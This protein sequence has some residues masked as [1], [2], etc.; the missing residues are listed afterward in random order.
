[1]ILETRHLRLVTAV[2][3]HG[4]LT[5]AGRELNLT[6]SA[7]SHALL[8]LERRL[9]APLF[10]RVGKRMVPTAVGERLVVRARRV[11]QLLT[12]TEEEA[13]RIASG[14][15]GLIRLS[16][17]CYTCYHWLPGLMQAFG[18]RFPNVEVR[19][20]AEATR[21]PFRALLEGRI[22]LAIVHNMSADARIRHA[23]LFEDEL[24]VLTPPDHPFAR[25]AF[26]APEEL[27]A[28]HLLTYRL[29]LRDL[30]IYQ[31]VLGP[32]G[33]TPRR[34]TQ[35]ELT[36]ALIEMVRAGMGVA[37]LAQWAVA[38]YVQAGKLTTTRFTE[39]GLHRRWS[40]ALLQQPSVPLHLREFINLLR[41]GPAQAPA[42]ATAAD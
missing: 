7:L 41:T 13:L 10:H 29:P 27:V 19:I 31:Q 26:V 3:D 30:S 24:V 42:V 25:Q 37:V 40:A 33:V 1:M 36:E 21:R 5:R 6:Q 14:L 11:L 39:G 32:A 28:E 35:I 9:G 15:E 34:V 8:D 4:T 12:E 18:Q 38:P 20:V 16:T 22:D 2:T 23:A 17:E